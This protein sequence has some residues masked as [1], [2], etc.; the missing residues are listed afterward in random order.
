[1]MT[2][3]VTLVSVI[4]LHRFSQSLQLTVWIKFFLPRKRAIAKGVVDLVE[5]GIISIR[6][7]RHS[8]RVV[9]SEKI[10]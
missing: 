8:V 9:S 6:D 2:S 7:E 10:S 3:T 4:E 5:E 1:M